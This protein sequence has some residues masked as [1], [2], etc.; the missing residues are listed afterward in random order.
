MFRHMYK[1]LLRNM[2][3]NILLTSQFTLAIIALIMFMIEAVNIIKSLTLDL[4][5]KVDRLIVGEVSGLWDVK[6]KD[7]FTENYAALKSAM[8]DLQKQDFVESAGYMLYHPYSGSNWDSWG[9]SINF[10]TIDAQKTLDF[11]L[12]YGEFFTEQDEYSPNNY[13]IINLESYNEF[14][15]VDPEPLGKNFHELQLALSKQDPDFEERED[16]EEPPPLIIKGVIQN[17]HMMGRYNHWTSKQRIGQTFYSNLDKYSKDEWGDITRMHSFIVRIKPGE[18][19][20]DAK[21]KVFNIMNSHLI[22]KNL[23]IESCE[24][25]E[26]VQSREPMARFYILLFVSFMLILIIT[27]GIYGISKEN[28]TKRIREIGIRIAFGGTEKQVFKQMIYEYGILSGLSIIVS[29]LLMFVMDWTGIYSYQFGIY[30]TLLA[31]VIQ[32]IVIF[33]SIANTIKS[34]TVMRPNVALHY[35]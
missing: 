4:G 16:H 31:I 34:A 1:M 2:R 19:Q 6:T 13:C 30:E 23:T 12:L 20:L 10:M 27:V 8:D 24:L 18:N 33:L 9:H 3:K 7:V 28:V 29:V 17:F 11:K 21:F 32:W 22:G 14:K 26:E 25:L 15:K 35:E 5:Y